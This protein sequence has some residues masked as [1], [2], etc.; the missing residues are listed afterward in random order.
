MSGRN[1]A[2]RWRNGRFVLRV[3]LCVDYPR[4]SSRQGEIDERSGDCGN[5]D[6]DY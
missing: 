6:S 5:E 2:V 4:E 1:F 3:G